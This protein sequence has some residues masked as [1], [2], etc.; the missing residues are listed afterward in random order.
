MTLLELQAL[1]TSQLVVMRALFATGFA[2]RQLPTEDR[3]L[4]ARCATVCGRTINSR[5]TPR[6]KARLEKEIL[7]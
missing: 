3:H 2:N 7:S 5:A 1:P 6:A 4:A